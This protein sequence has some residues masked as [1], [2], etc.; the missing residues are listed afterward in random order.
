[1]SFGKSEEISYEQE[2][3]YELLKHKDK[4]DL[5]GE[6]EYRRLCFNNLK[7]LLSNNINV[8][9]ITQ[10]IIPYHPYNITIFV[11]SISKNVDIDIKWFNGYK[12]IFKKDLD[13]WKRKLDDIYEKLSDES[14]K[15]NIKWD[16][17]Y[18]EWDDWFLQKTPIKR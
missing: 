2:C 13:A 12:V 11:V 15:L 6:L 5:Y 3:M 18:C 8:I 10:N 4:L 16:D 17:Y 7:K 9:D 1:M 14:N